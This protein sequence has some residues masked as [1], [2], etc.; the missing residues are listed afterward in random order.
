[1]NLRLERRTHLD[2]L[3]SDT[4][5]LDERLEWPATSEL[6]V[7]THTEVET[8]P[9]SHVAIARLSQV[10]DDGG[11]LRLRE[12]WAGESGDGELLEDRRSWLTNNVMLTIAVNLAQQHGKSADTGKS[13]VEEHLTLADEDVLDGEPWVLV[14][15]ADEV[16]VH[17]HQAA[18]SKW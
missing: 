12:A 7:A 11:L 4:R 10:E 5:L 15:G 9:C 17:A 13:S 6:M 18:L 1:M 2:H 16:L 3:V 14:Q 8:A